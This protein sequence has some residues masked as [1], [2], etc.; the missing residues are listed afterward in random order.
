MTLQ[1]R[2]GIY[3]SATYTAPHHQRGTSCYRELSKQSTIYTDADYE[4]HTQSATVITIFNGQLKKTL[5][6]AAL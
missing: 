6:S 3:S 5:S 1:E 4:H 2:E